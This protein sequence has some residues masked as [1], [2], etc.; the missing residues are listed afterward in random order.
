MLDSWM[1]DDENVD[2]YFIEYEKAF[3]N[4]TEVDDGNST[5]PN[6]KYWTMPSED[7]P[8]RN[9]TYKDMGSQNKSCSMMIKPAYMYYGVYP[10]EDDIRAEY[11]WADKIDIEYNY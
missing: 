6:N 1:M 3:I 11:P 2:I 9:I 10:R 4:S 8:P 5:D 7:K